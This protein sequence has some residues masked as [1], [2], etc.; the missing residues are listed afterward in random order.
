MD[1]STKSIKRI[2]PFLSSILCLFLS[3]CVNLEPMDDNTRFF[4]IDPTPN[5]REPLE[6]SSIHPSIYFPQIPLPEFL[7]TS[8]LAVIHSGTEL[9]F[10]ETHRWAEPLD[11]SLLRAMVS[12]TR[13]GLPKNW[14]ITN[15]PN[16]R[17]DEKGIEIQIEVEQLEG[18]VAGTAHFAGQF[19]IFTHME[20]NLGRQLLHHQHFHYTTTWNSSEPAELPGKMSILVQQL[21]ETILQKL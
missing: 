17:T 13:K 21:S 3:S 10:Y 9:R 4:I 6:K 5:Q 20:N 19:H 8:K 18:N 2:L 15:F 11:D 1:P 16:R 12:H 7:S 14:T